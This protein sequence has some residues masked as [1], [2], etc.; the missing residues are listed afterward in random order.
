MREGPGREG[1]AWRKG[2]E[3]GGKH[4]N[5]GRQ[6]QQAP[7]ATQHFLYLQMQED[8]NYELYVS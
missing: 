2:R 4:P 8:E 7:E 3:Q 5:P 1:G 6:T